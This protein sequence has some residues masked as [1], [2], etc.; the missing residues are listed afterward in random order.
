MSGLWDS[1]YSQH[2]GQVFTGESQALEVREALL[3]INQLLDDLLAAEPGAKKRPPE[4]EPASRLYL[5]LFQDRVEMTRDELSKTLRGTQVEPNDLQARGWARIVGTRVH[6]VP[7]DE[8][9]S[10]FTQRGRTR[11]AALKTD[12]DQAH[13][14]IGAARDS[15]G[16][17]I[18][19]ELD[20]WGGSLKRS[21][22]AILKWYAE[23]AGHA[24]TKDAAGRAIRLVEAWRSKPRK[25]AAEQ[26]TLF[27]M[28]E[29]EA[30]SG[31]A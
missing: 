14:L 26:M 25:V 19:R 16:L 7:L 31:A 29:Q 4:C 6:A 2:Y 17:S 15:S 9:M 18:D 21:T 12:L 27:S 30:E 28:L 5:S 20:N 1:L 13:F 24:E 22:D 11:K 8:R 10:H 23:T 3:G